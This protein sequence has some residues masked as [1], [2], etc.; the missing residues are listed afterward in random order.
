MPEL[1]SALLAAAADPDVH[2]IALYVD[3]PGGTA[4]GTHELA[5]AVRVAGEAKPVEAYVS[6]LAASG[7][8]WVG[9]QAQRVTVN[10]PG[11]VGSIGVF[12]IL[13]DFSKAADRAGLK[14]HRITTGPFKGAGAPGIE[15][16]PEQLA[17]W[18]VEVEAVFGLFVDAVAKGRGLPPARVRKL[19][20]GRLYV[21]QR[22]VDVGLADAVGTFAD[23]VESLLQVRRRR[24]AGRVPIAALS[25]R[26]QVAV[27]ANRLGLQPQELRQVL[28]AAERSPRPKARPKPVA[29]GPFTAEDLRWLEEKGISPADAERIH[30]KYSRS[31]N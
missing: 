13:V 18:Q 1:R 23:V 31:S 22:A 6:D 15:I 11:R 12:S 28:A 4:E 17:A 19:A 8:Y 7:A 9:C 20:D 27:L 21:G 2:A 29:A 5:E 3:S 14:F 24:P 26:Q 25:E 10:A 16:T 30:R